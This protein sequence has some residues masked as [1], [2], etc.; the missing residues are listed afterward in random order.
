[1][2]LNGGLLEGFISTDP[3][4][5]AAWQS[6][7]WRRNFQNGTVLVSPR[8]NNSN[9]AVTVQDVGHCYPE[10]RAVPPRLVGFR[11]VQ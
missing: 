11:H 9:A 3:P 6:G 2:R 5:T 4:P 10:Q 7:V 8:G 1:M